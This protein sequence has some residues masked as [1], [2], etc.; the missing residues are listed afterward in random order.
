MAII[1][2]HHFVIS[3]DFDGDFLITF[4][5]VA[6]SNDIAKNSLASIAIHYVTLVQLLSN[7]DTVVA[8]CVVPVISQ[9]WVL[10]KITGGDQS[11]PW[12]L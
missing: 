11:I 10:I 12:S 6:C 8:L 5:G 9:C 7:A 1:G 3:N 2:L 4:H